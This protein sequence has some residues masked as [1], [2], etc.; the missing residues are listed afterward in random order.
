MVTR[1]EMTCEQALEHLEKQ[2]DRLA[3]VLIHEFPEAWNNSD[4]H[5]GACDM[6]IRFMREQQEALKLC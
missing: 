3:E 6:A 2:V 5:E 4:G 1:E